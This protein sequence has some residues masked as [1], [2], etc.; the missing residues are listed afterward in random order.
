MSAFV[1]FLTSTTSSFSASLLPAVPE[2]DELDEEYGEEDEEEAPK[3]ES[4]PVGPTP[5]E[6]RT[7]ILAA[8]ARGAA[9]ARKE[10]AEE[11]E[12]L[13]AREADLE[14]L[15]ARVEATRR[16]DRSET[17]QLIGSLII[18]SMRRLIG[19]HPILR[20]A[21]LRHAFA[22]AVAGM[23]GD[24]DVVLWVAPGQEEI[25]RELIEEREGWSVR[26]STDLRAGLQVVGPRGRLDSSLMT[27]LI[28]MEA[29]VN[30][31]LEERP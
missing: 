25:A 10:L 30:A 15:I 2:P 23:I 6:I 21:A 28:A 17:R 16:S 27:A 29:A 5:E 22:Q 14:A 8:E 12:R 13:A 24:R 3:V 31:W 18:A 1:P 11:A 26:V 4:R 19:E 7:L 9:S 20:E